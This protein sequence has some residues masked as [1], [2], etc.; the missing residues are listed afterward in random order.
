MAL[1]LNVYFFLFCGGIGNIFFSFLLKLCVC[2]ILLDE[3]IVLPWF[4][5]RFIRSWFRQIRVLTKKNKNWLY[6]ENLSHSR[7]VSNMNTGT[8][9]NGFVCTMYVYAVAPELQLKEQTTHCSLYIHTNSLTLCHFFILVCF[10]LLSA[11]ASIKYARFA[12]VYWI[13]ESHSKLI[14]CTKMPNWYNGP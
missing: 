13:V 1:L 14:S 12:N 10:Q 2:F 8:D 9:C 7:I 3:K 11:P 6:F 4:F 5:F